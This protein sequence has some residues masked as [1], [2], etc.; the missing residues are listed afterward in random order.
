MAYDQQQEQQHWQQQQ[1]AWQQP[2]APPT[3]PVSTDAY[4]QPQQ[5]L[6]L[7]DADTGGD[8]A[9]FDSDTQLQLAAGDV[10]ELLERFD[11][12]LVDLLVEVER[13]EQQQQARRQHQQQQQRG[14]RQQ[15]Q[16]VHQQQDVSP[17]QQ[18]G[19]NWDGQTRSYVPQQHSD[20]WTCP[21]HQQQQRRQQSFMQPQQQPA[22]RG[23]RGGD[24]QRW[25]AGA[26]YAQPEDDEV[27]DILNF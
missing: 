10:R 15:Q 8:A 12:S 7:A 18:L 11:E 13:L 4:H 25:Q 24:V 21:P 6:V 19:S 5:Q 1:Q 26:A 20:R 27:S 3:Q 23:S 17:P 16:P 22:V 9:E 2:A 14:R